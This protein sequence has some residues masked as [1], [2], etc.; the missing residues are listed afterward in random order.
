MAA[1]RTY[2]VHPTALFPAGV[3]V[4]LQMCTAKLIVEEILVCV[5][6][7]LTKASLV[8]TVRVYYSDH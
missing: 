7:P 2:L 5:Q 1:H 4:L 6:E 8:T 3:F